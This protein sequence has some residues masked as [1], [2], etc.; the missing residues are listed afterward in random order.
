MKHGKGQHKNGQQSTNMTI[1]AEN[2]GGG[3]YFDST[4]H[5]LKSTHKLVSPHP[6]DTKSHPITFFRPFPRFPEIDEKD[7]AIKESR[8]FWR[9]NVPGI[10]ECDL[11]RTYAVMYGLGSANLFSTISRKYLLIT[12]HPDVFSFSDL[13]DLIIS[14][15]L[16]FAVTPSPD[17]A[18]KISVSPVDAIRR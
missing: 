6:T 16:P 13:T 18:E 2:A 4:I 7:P 17:F 9:F 15:T 14:S 5:P 12:Y 3:G 10:S 8:V 11:R 1:M